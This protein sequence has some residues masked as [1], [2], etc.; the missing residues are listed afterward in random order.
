[1]IGID[2]Q[3]V[4]DLTLFNG[5]KPLKEPKSMMTFKVSETASNDLPTFEMKFATDIPNLTAQM[6]DGQ[7]MEV[8]FG[9]SQ[10]NL[11]NFTAFP[12]M[13]YSAQDG[14]GLYEYTVKGTCGAGPEYYARTRTGISRS[15]KAEDMV[16]RVAE[17]HFKTQFDLTT[18]GQQSWIQPTTSDKQF[19]DHLVER[20][21][22]PG[23]W[24]SSAINLRGNRFR[25]LDMARRQNLPHD[26]VFTPDGSE[27]LMYLQANVTSRGGITNAMAGYG[28]QMNVFDTAK[29][30]FKALEG[31]LLEPISLAK[32][33]AAAI[34]PR[35]GTMRFLSPNMNPNYF[36][37]I[38]NN[39]VNNVANT[40]L[41]VAVTFRNVFAKLSSLDT[42]LLLENARPGRGAGQVRMGDTTDSGLYIIRGVEY[43]LFQDNLMSTAYLSRSFPGL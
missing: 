35:V 7:P 27:G 4:F 11:V 33:A 41:T 29:G 28:K 42:V 20:A 31:L 9:L 37:A 34:F 6:Q 40:A 19:M 2:N 43:E 24:V 17:R 38:A 3:Y 13:V 8:S 23:S 14:Q 15:R 5:V 30:G 36:D 1:M 16:K 10:S 12:M 26:W 32:K 22:I 21:S 25:M 18:S 39:N